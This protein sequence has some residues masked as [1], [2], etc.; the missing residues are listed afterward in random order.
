MFYVNPT[1]KPS[2][3]YELYTKI[4]S[5]SSTEEPT[6][7]IIS[8]ITSYPTIFIPQSYSCIC[9]LERNKN[10]IIGTLSVSSLSAFLT[11]IFIIMKLYNKKN[12]KNKKNVINDIDFGIGS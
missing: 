9:E 7:S 10:L 8:K 5:S 12:K 1:I 3:N 2:Y 11:I 6:E 4:L